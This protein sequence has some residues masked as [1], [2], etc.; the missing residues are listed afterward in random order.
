LKGALFALL[1]GNT[2][3]YLVAGTR[4]EA[5]DSV[6]WLTLLVSFELET[7]RREWFRGRWSTIALRGARLLAAAALAVAAVGYVRGKEWLDAINVGL[8][9]GVVALLEFEVR[10]PDAVMRHRGGF[11]AVTTALY[12]GLVGLVLAWLLRGEWFD[13]Y[14]AALWLAAFATLEMDLLGQFRNGRSAT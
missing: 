1:A 12:A 5:L 9:I 13:A 7:G 3:V 2:A 4:S 14:D 10:R 6:A 8:W 11:L